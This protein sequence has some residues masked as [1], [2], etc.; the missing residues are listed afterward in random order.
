MGFFRPLRSRRSDPRA[1]PVTAW[2]RCEIDT[3]IDRPVRHRASV[4]R[5]S[6]DAAKA[7]GFTHIFAPERRFRNGEGIPGHAARGWKPLARRMKPRRVA[8]L[9][10]GVW[11]G[12]FLVEVFR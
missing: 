7:E 11:T 10:G 5:P 12:C 3:E 4:P 2:R 9:G 8:F 1:T 6:R